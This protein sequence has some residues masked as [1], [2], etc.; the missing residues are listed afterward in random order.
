MLGKIGLINHSNVS[1]SSASNTE[2]REVDG[3]G[4]KF[5]HNLHSHDIKYMHACYLYIYTYIECDYAVHNI[6]LINYYS[7]TRL[8]NQTNPFVYIRRESH[9][10]I[11]IP[12]WDK[13][14]YPSGR[15]S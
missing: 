6:Y 2:V 15:V 10:L 11:Y 8:E 9:T 5:W 14:Y 12:L 1:S 7:Q 13:N 4:R 3:I